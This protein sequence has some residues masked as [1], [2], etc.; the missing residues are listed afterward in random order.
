MA[1]IISDAAIK[2]RKH[3]IEEIKKL[4][5]DFSADSTR[6][7][8]ELEAELLSTGGAGLRNHL[9]LCGAIPEVYAHDSSEEKLYSKYTD[10]LAAL[11]FV[12]ISGRGTSWQPSLYRI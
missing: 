2:N 9:R 7:H 4:S 12:S 1:T 10:V 6:L 3:W 8:S 11:A 5:D